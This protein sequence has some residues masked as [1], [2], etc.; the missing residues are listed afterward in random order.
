M[1]TYITLGMPSEELFLV[2]YKVQAWDTPAF[3]AGLITQ[4]NIFHD[5]LREVWP[6]SNIISRDYSNGLEDHFGLIS[7]I[8]AGTVPIQIQ[9]I[10]VEKWI[11]TGNNLY[12]QALNTNPAFFCQIYLWFLRADEVNTHFGFISKSVP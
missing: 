7:H 9:W 12:F 4:F 5:K 1:T 3:G 2:G 8:P 10:P 6:A 11:P